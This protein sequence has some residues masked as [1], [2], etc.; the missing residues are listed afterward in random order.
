MTRREQQTAK[1]IGE[2]LMNIGNLS[3]RKVPE[4]IDKKGIQLS[5]RSNRHQGQRKK[6]DYK[7]LFENNP[8]FE[9][10]RYLQTDEGYL[11]VQTDVMKL[12]MGLFTFL[13][14]DRNIFRY[15]YGP[16][17]FP[18]DAHKVKPHFYLRTYHCCE[19][20][21]VPENPFIHELIMGSF[22]HLRKLSD[23][24]SLEFIKILEDKEQFRKKRTTC[25]RD[26]N[27]IYA[28]SG[29]MDAFTLTAFLLSQSEE[30]RFSLWQRLD[31]TSEQI[32]LTYQKLK[33]VELSFDW[34]GVS[35]HLSRDIER[36]DFPWPFQGRKD[37]VLKCLQLWGLI[38]LD[39]SENF[40]GLTEKGRRMISWLRIYVKGLINY[41]EQGEEGS[42][43]Y[44]QLLHLFSLSQNNKND[45]YW[46]DFSKIDTGLLFTDSFKEVLNDFLRFSNLLERKKYIKTQKQAFSSA[47]K[48]LLLW[49]EGT[50]S[51][52]EALKKLQRRSRVDL[53]SHIVL[54]ISQRENNK[55]LDTDSRA[56]IVFPILTEYE[57]SRS[58]YHHVGFFLGT[59]MDVNNKGRGYW[60]G[61]ME[62][63]K[64][65]TKQFKELIETMKNIMGTI[66]LVEA[67]E[68]YYGE[69]GKI[70]EQ[71]KI[72]HQENIKER[73]AAHTLKTLWDKFGEYSNS[74]IPQCR[75]LATLVSKVISFSMKWRQYIKKYELV[76][77][78]LSYYIKFQDF[79][80][81]I[82]ALALLIYKR[83]IENSISLNLIDSYILKISSFRE[84]DEQRTSFCDKAYYQDHFLSLLNLSEEIINR[85]QNKHLIFLPYGETNLMFNASASKA[86]FYSALLTFLELLQNSIKYSIDWDNKYIW[87]YVLEHEKLILF[88]EKEIIIT[89][90]TLKPLISPSSIENSAGLNSFG[91]TQLSAFFEAN[92]CEFRTSDGINA[93]GNHPNFLRAISYSNSNLFKHG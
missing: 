18:E 79:L 10:Y 80:T 15:L 43:S 29:E 74:E 9:L 54:R 25:E 81:I 85:S 91:L 40:M 13:D 87:C 30:V 34:K 61:L 22:Y 8:Y 63:D 93:G 48:I 76:E 86:N 75:K 6:D 77:E 35:K 90:D 55:G 37:N 51:V 89:T 5:V 7:F 36:A 84:Y 47:L 1:I 31:Q 62:G 73:S 21:F 65:L 60:E 53:M 45:F 28:P 59:F 71:N 50:T 12:Q 68:I 17:D 66:S 38:K 52:E 26:L 69:I 72:L 4:K 49:N 19:K 24:R 33:E 56:W 16:Q 32:N 46:L 92:N 88:S 83:E 23:Y 67:R 64:T 39:E 27:I 3:N 70:V 14:R 2:V 78:N 58:E 82:Y 44:K 20:R 41:L 11:K 57:S 42:K